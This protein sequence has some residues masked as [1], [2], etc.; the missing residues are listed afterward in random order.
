MKA[1]VAC[2]MQFGIGFKNNLLHTSAEDFEWFIKHTKGRPIVMGYNTFVSLPR[3][4]PNRPHI[5]FTN[6]LHVP[7]VIDKVRYT[8]AKYNQEPNVYVVNSLERF[9]QLCKEAGFIQEDCVVIGGQQIYKLFEDRID[10]V[11]LTQIFE[12]YKEVDTWFPINLDD[13]QWKTEHVVPRLTK[14]HPR[15]EFNIVTRY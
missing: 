1:I 12:T 15:L 5:V 13:W 7:E 14:N 3:V 11:Y 2:D 9:D 10:L 8:K 4:L 6:K